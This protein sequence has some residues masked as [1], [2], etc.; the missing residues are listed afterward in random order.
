MDYG[1]VTVDYENFLRECHLIDVQKHMI[2]PTNKIMDVCEEYNIPVTF[3]CNMPEVLA[4]KRENHPDFSK[5]EKQLWDMVCRG[6]DIQMHFHPQWE[7]F[8]W[9]NGIWKNHSSIDFWA[10][11]MNFE[12]FEN[13]FKAG[14]EYAR[15]FSD[16]VVAFRGGGYLI[17]PLSTNIPV[18]E[19]YGL[20]L[21]SSVTKSMPQRCIFSQQIMKNN[22]NEIPPHVFNL[23]SKIKEI[24]ICSLGQ[25]RWDMS[26][27][28]IADISII[29]QMMKRYSHKSKDCFYVMMGHNKQK[30][31]FNEL[32]STFSGV[33]KGLKFITF[34][35]ASRILGKAPI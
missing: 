25:Q 10:D 27:G 16:K 18:L 1:L 33:V 12:D 3:F 19:K 6:H 21:D 26:S 28:R 13:S 31:F 23:S 5:I 8:K 14:I 4:F 15:Q 7:N 20:S 34:A 30:I 24:P 17:E 22:D 29:S 2:N 11:E 9:E 32:K 35:E